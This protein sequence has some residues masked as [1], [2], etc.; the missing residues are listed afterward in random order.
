MQTIPDSEP[1]ALRRTDAPARRR[2]VRL[3]TAVLAVAAATAGLA[4]C[5]S[6]GKTNGAS[7][8][9]GSGT[10]SSGSGGASATD[11][12]IAGH[13]ITADPAL[14]AQLPAAIKSKGELTDITYNNA[15]PDESVVNGKLVGWEV[16]LGAAVAATLGLKWNVTASGAFDSFIPGLQNGRYNVSFTSFIQTPDRLKQI[17]IVTYY[18]IGTGFAVK[19]GNSLSIKTPTDVCGHSVSVIAGSAFIQQ[20]QGIKC[21]AAGKPAVKVQSF[22]SDSAAELAVSSGRVEIYSSSMDQLSWLVE[23]AHGQF[24]LQP[25]DYQPVPEG[26]GVSKGIGLTKPIADAMDK[27]IQTGVYRDIMKKWS[28]TQGGLVTKSTIYS[29]SGATGS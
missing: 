18:N 23:Q 5:S 19:S 28:I 27:V 1:Q 9:T 29:T 4:A 7:S 11:V 15:P 17:D 22:P 2:R 26:A 25:L 13:T 8:T 24:V 21:A 12:S 14:V 3:V 10:S 20:L 6:S 16:D